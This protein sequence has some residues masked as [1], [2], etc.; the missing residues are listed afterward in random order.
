MEELSQLTPYLPYL[1]PLIIIQF[2]LM[3]FA[4]VDVIRR[5]RTF[6]PKWFWLVLILAVNLFGPLAYF[7]FGRK[8]E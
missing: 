3:I 4:L 2:A 8:D 6:G 1:I 5:E 7:I